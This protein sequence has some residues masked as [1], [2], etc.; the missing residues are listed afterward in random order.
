MKNI[1][2][3][4]DDELEGRRHKVWA[5]I[6]L[7]ALVHNY[8]RSLELA[9]KKKNGTKVIPVIKADAYGHGAV[10][11]MLALKGAGADFFAVS[12]VAEAIE[13]KRTGEAED[14]D[15]LI[16]G[17]TDEKDADLLAR[18]DLIQ[19]VHSLEYAHA[20]ESA[21][22]KLGVDMRVHIKLDTG[23]NRLGFST[24]DPDKAMREM[25]ELARLERLSCEGVFSH[26]ACAD[27]RESGLTELQL[28]R[29][30]DLLSAMR[31][32][33]ICPSFCHISNSAGI[34][35]EDIPQYSAVRAGIILY[36]HAPSS[37]FDVSEFENVMTLKARI[38]HIHEIDAGET[39]G[40]GATFKADKRM[41][42]A[43]LPIGYA[44]GFIRAYSGAYVKLGGK[45]CPIVGRICMDQCMIDISGVDARLGDEVVLF[46]SREDTQRLAELAGTI[47]YEILCLISKRVPRIYIREPHHENLK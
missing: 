44:D 36:G 12:S 32:E 38:A 1:I 43:T 26:F 37:E 20:L 35:R 11:S 18:Y 6:D 23:M 30:N 42:I 10:K 9:E 14:I 3:V 4:L 25:R 31:S 15:V 7:S 24:V 47:P 8:E 39:V 27:E 13:L 5:E 17:Y 21:A 29:F 40:Y 41:K 16:L 19:T 22:E 2:D 28:K 45:R 33:N 34:L 46:D